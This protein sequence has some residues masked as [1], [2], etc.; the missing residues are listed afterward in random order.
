MTDAYFRLLFYEQQKLLPGWI[1]NGYRDE[2]RE[3]FHG[4]ALDL[5]T[6]RALVL[7]GGSS[8]C[9]E[10]RSCVVGTCKELAVY[11]WVEDDELV[12]GTC[13]AHGRLVCKREVQGDD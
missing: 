11:Q 4:R 1:N 8:V 13:P 2:G 9:K 12:V 10:N 3:A 5:L 6:R 7:A